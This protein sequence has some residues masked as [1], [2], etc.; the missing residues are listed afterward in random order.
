MENAGLYNLGDTP[1]GAADAGS[2]I[3]AGVSSGG[4]AQAFLDSLDGM[5]SCTLQ[6]NFAY[7]SDGTTLAIIVETSLDQ[8]AT[9]IEVAAFAFATASAEKLI[10]LVADKEIVAAYTPG[11]LPD[12]TG[13]SGIFG[14]RWRARKISTGVYAGNSAVSVRMVAR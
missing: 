1:I 11:A 10:T 14:E 4:V 9:W 12:D 7:G 3:T 2:V 6:A 13:K 5:S 8:G